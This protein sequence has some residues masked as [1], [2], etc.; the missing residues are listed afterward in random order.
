MTQ[1]GADTMPV[2]VQV[3]TERLMKDEA[4]LEID[5]H[6]LRAGVSIRT[7]G[8]FV[9]DRTAVGGILQ[10]L[11]STNNNY[12]TVADLFRND[13]RFEGTFSMD[14]SLRTKLKLSLGD[15]TR[16]ST[17]VRALC[18]DYDMLGGPL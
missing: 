6:F 4:F 3:D 10:G 2:T 17:C 1:V 9:R 8:L 14:A 15:L 18:A 16:V 7:G 5:T 12:K 11:S 13:Y